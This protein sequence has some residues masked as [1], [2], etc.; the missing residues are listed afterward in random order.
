MG[1]QRENNSDFH[2]SF[3]RVIGGMTCEWNRLIHALEHVAKTLEA[4]C[5]LAEAAVKAEPKLKQEP[6][7]ES[8]D[9]L[10]G[11]MMQGEIT[12]DDRAKKTTV[13][14][15]FED[16]N[17]NFVMVDYVIQNKAQ[18]AKLRKA[19]AEAED[20]NSFSFYDAVL[21]IIGERQ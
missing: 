8:S 2:M 7:H 9:G 14:F 11:R 17:G 20:Q 4:F 13:V 10:M 21:S 18:K 19:M 15:Q 6:W 1:Q 12:V 3:S 5:S 16:P